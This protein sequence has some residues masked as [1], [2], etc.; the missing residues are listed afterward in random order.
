MENTLIPGTK[1]LVQVIYDSLESGESIDNAK[2]TDM[3]NRSF[4]GSRSAGTY[5]PRYAYD[6]CEIAVN[7]LLLKSPVKLMEMDAK[8]AL[9]N[10]IRPLLARLPR[11][12]DRTDQQIELQQFST[13]PHLAYICAKLSD[14]KMGDEYFEPSAGT[15]SLAV[16]PRS[17]DL[18]VSCNDI[19]QTRADMGFEFLGFPYTCHPGEH[20]ADFL[21]LDIHPNKILMNPPFSATGG[22]VETHDSLYGS[23]HVRSALKLLRDGGRLVAIVGEGMGIDK[24]KFGPFWALMA[25]KYNI[26]ANYNLNGKEYGKYGTT[27]GVNIL[28][29]DK[30]GPTPGKSWAQQ[31]Q[32]IRFGHADSLEDLWDEVNDVVK[33]PETEVETIKEHK[34]SSVFVPYLTS[35]IEGGCAHPAMVTE[36]STMAAVSPPPITYHPHLP[37]EVITDG[38]LSDLQM[39]SIIYAGQRHEQRLADGS[40]AGF[41]IGSST[42]VGKGRILAGIIADNWFQGRRK[43]IFFSVNNVLIEAIRNDL[44]DIGVEIPL[45]QVNQYNAL[46]PID[47]KEG[48]I[49]SSYSSL[50]AKTRTGERRIDQIRTW[51]GTDALVL[52]DES[53]KGKNSI[54]GG[55]GDGSQTGQAMIDIQDPIL[56]PDYRIVYS[57]ATGATE[58]RN[59]A[60]MTRLGLWGEGTSFPDGFKQFLDEID[61]GGVAA[62]EMI[63]RDMKG[64]GMYLSA[65][66]SLGECP[67]SHK[68]VEYRESIHVLTPQQEEMYN[69]SAQAWQFLLQNI[70]HALEI[71]NGSTRSQGSSLQKFWGDH[72]RFF[73]QMIC[74]LKVSTIIKETETSLQEGKSVVI[75]LI[76]TGEARTRDQVSKTIAA[77]GLLEDLDFSPRE[78]IA[79]MIDRGFPTVL[80]QEVSRPG[81][82][83]TIKVPVTDKDGNVVHSQEALAL[84]QTLLDGLSSLDLPENPLDQLINYFGPDKVAELTGRSKRLIR[85]HLAGTVEYKKRNPDGIAMHQVNLYEMDLFQSGHKRIAI[86]SDASSMGISLHASNRAIN[87][88]RRVHI[89]LELNWSADKQMQTFGRTHRSDQAIPPE[90]ILCMTNLHGEKRFASTIAH[91]LQS[92]G[93]LTQGE[94]HAADSGDL[95]KYN[96][97]TPEGRASLRLTLSEIKKGA[98][99]PGLIN[100]KQT[101]RDIGLLSKDAEGVERI[102]KEDEDHVPRFLNRVLALCVNEQNALFDYFVSIFDQTIAFAKANGTFDEGVVDIKAVSMELSKEPNLIHTDHVTGAE[103]IHYSLKAEIPVQPL[104]FDEVNAIRAD[105]NRRASFYQLKAELGFVLAV[106]S[107]RHTDPGTGRTFET[108]GIWTPQGQHVKYVTQDDLQQK[109]RFCTP[110]SSKSWWEKQYQDA[111]K[112]KIEELHIIA[113][114]IIPLWQKLKSHKDVTLHVVRV[115][116]QDGQRIVGVRIPRHHIWRILHSFGQVIEANGT[117]SIFSAVKDDRIEIPLTSGLKLAPSII[118]GEI[119]I[120]LKD[121]HPNQYG[122]FRRMGFME[123]SIAYKRRFFIPTNFTLGEGILLRLLDAYP[124]VNTSPIEDVQIV[125]SP[126]KKV[127]T[128]KLEDWIIQPEGWVNTLP[129]INTTSTTESIAIYN[130]VRDEQ[131]QKQEKIKPRGKWSNPDQYAFTFQPL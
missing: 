71:T 58:V 88:Q 107:G 7:K 5:T 1:R 48:V 85:D 43:T 13:P 70:R 25:G 95:A 45:V 110:H 62:M 96:F 50:I 123:E 29:I 119:R 55:Y 10:V 94:R 103:T 84:Q 93:A 22:R 118:H 111:P 11:Q 100:A 27:F 6:C 117:Q 34:N 73:R 46:D 36:S 16:W 66:L 113:G 108:F 69:A 74:A 79:G 130:S 104:R 78:I 120:E 86:I 64:L 109:Y 102:K 112:T 51:L 68:A 98:E 39:E 115:T 90:Y 63:C 33:R 31:V 126:V 59:M 23:M 14:P 54:S 44:R 101:L 99:V 91:R 52:F 92:L 128:I 35:R 42:G 122:Q 19:D 53:S 105:P 61:A 56:G 57:S 32:N 83:G 26:L 8:E 129:S 106:P 30:T 114:A 47:I 75:S 116:L 40:R 67:V 97:E 21:K 65:S 121:T 28:V 9:S 124:L 4:D 17:L 82:P 37:L 76:G 131:K 60:Y 2:L 80:Y 20:I 15:C 12:T 87:K 18:Q 127:E 77:G 49:F 3:A 125:Y 89:T 24:P 41:F 81:M 72:Q 38:R